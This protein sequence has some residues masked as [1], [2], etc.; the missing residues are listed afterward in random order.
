MEDPRLRKLLLVK[1]IIKFL[2]LE[3]TNPELDDEQRA[4]LEV[5][6]QCI[7]SVYC[8]EGHRNDTDALD[9]LDLVQKTLTANQQEKEVDSIRKKSCDRVKYA[10]FS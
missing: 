6:I 1:S 7:E 8:V 10:V 3:L 9:L 2:A 4:T 5:A